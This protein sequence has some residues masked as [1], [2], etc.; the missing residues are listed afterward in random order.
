MRYFLTFFCFFFYICCAFAASNQ[1]PAFAS[2]DVKEEII[3][4]E[5]GI[6]TGTKGLGKWQQTDFG[7]FRLISCSGGIP[8]NNVPFL[9]I[10]GRL[11]DGWRLE[12]PL[13][14][15]STDENVLKEEILY[16]LNDLNEKRFLGYT[17]EVYFSLVQLLKE[18]VTEFTVNKKFLVKACKIDYCK[19][20]MLDLSLSLKRDSKYPTDVCTKMMRRFQMMIKKPQID[21]IQTT[22]SILDENHLQLIASF[23][24]D[25]SF[26]EV[27]TNALDNYEILRKDFQGNT[28]SLL[29]KTKT[30]NLKD[31]FNVVL[32]S[33]LGFFQKEVIPQKGVFHF[34]KEEMSIFSAIVAGI[35]LFLLSP[36]FYLFLSLPNEKDALLLKVKQIKK[37]F[38]LTFF[39]LMMT[40]YFKP[41]LIDLFEI[42][43]SLI[44]ISFMVLVYLLIWPKFSLIG[45]IVLFFLF[46]KPYLM[47]SLSCLE[48]MDGRVVIL[49]V[50]W[51]IIALL[52]FEIFK[53][54][55]MLFEELKKLKQYPVL[56]RLPQGVLLLWLII[57]YMGN[58]FYPTSDAKEISSLKEGEQTIFV[59][60]EKGLCLTCFLN[61]MTL[62]YYLENLS[63]FDQRKVHILSIDVNNDSA[64]EFLKG[65]KLSLKTNALLFGPNQSFPEKV[66]G[67]IPIDGWYRWLKKVMPEEKIK[68]PDL[69][70]LDEK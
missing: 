28:A 43:G 8:E 5:Q 53:K 23:Q 54:V 22:L 40:F 24:K 36:L 60:A 32:I 55:P 6:F 41:N 15:A 66:F 35:L 39:F 47:E 65:H 52:P 45:A 25:V 64:Q 4:E 68:L 56:I 21:S 38:G 59:S 20:E 46:P 16:P 17:G 70:H 7:K 13:I 1:E 9:M 49:F 57:S 31:P 48:N 63:D 51:M 10:E 42:N 26:L 34:F 62:S 27:Q 3:F 14:P 11:L 37:A 67:F 33:S 69:I 12:K 30:T 2:S 29:I 19:E 50:V 44:L 61:K 58:W 18:S